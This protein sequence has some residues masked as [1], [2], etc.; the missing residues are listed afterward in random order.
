F[1]ALLGG[2]L[3]GAATAGDDAKKELKKFEGTWSVVSAAKFGKNVP[4][5]EIKNVKFVFEGEKMTVDDGKGGGG[6]AGGIKVDTYKKPAHL[7][8]TT[9]GKTYPGIYSL[10]NNELK[11]C[12]GESE[13]P[14]EF[15]SGE[16]TKT[17]LVVLK[18]EKK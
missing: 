5:K 9:K 13:R 15:A 2:L 10:K 1:V 8:I 3:V 14:S 17:V 6:D 4:E 7:D 12:F 18:R 11:I 16:G